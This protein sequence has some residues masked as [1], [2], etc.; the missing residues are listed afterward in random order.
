M[1]E[2]DRLYKTID[3]A[4][5]PLPKETHLPYPTDDEYNEW[6]FA[7]NGAAEDLLDAAKAVTS[8]G[9]VSIPALDRLTCIVNQLDEKRRELHINQEV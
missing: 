6:R 2:I 3:T 7:L 5:R 9:V 4:Y 1:L 8:K